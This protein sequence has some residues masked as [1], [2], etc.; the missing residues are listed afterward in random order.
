[1]QRGGY[2]SCNTDWEE[3]LQ[4]AKKVLSLHIQA[5]IEVDQTILLRLGCQ[6]CVRPKQNSHRYN[7]GMNERH[8]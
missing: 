6:M 8:E 2:W 3:H 5:Y 1:M 4:G 7:V